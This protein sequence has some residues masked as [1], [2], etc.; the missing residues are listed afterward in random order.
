MTDADLMKF[1]DRLK[2]LHIA[3]ADTSEGGKVTPYV[4][5]IPYQ[6]RQ[7]FLDSIRK[8]MYEGFG[9]LDVHS[10][11]AGDTNDH[12]EAA[13]QPMDENADDFEM[14]IIEFV[15]ALGGLI[16]L[17]EDDCVPIFKRNR[18]SN[19]KEQVEML[20]MEEPHLDDYTFL[21]KLPNISPDE[22]PEIMKRKSA[23]DIEKFM[24]NNVKEAHE[25][26]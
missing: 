21:S 14:Q 5:E 9:A 17:D 12:I 23:E 11:S 2:L 25:N 7:T 24:D 6:A 20:I 18:I 1:R 26:D 4:Q 16:G 8:E 19:Q 15:Q 3:E 13:H 22:I 10:I